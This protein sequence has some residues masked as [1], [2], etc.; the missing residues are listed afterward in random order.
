MVFGSFIIV[1]NAPQH[2]SLV[3]NNESSINVTWDPPNPPG[4]TTGY[5]VFYRQGTMI[6]SKTVTN[7]SSTFTVLNDLQPGRTYNV[8]VAGLSDHLPS[9]I[10]TS[11]IFLGEH[12]CCLTYNQPFFVLFF[13]TYSCAT[14]KHRRYFYHHEHRDLTNGVL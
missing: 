6:K 8:S 14:E 11:A 1:A 12:G 13:Y 7:A 4:N 5:K 2:I 9:D 3:Q 10:V